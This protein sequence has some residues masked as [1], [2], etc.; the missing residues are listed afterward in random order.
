MD[1]SRTFAVAVIAALACAC[2][3]V[4]GPGDFVPSVDDKVG[5]GSTYDSTDEVIPGDPCQ[6]DNPWSCD[7]ITNEGCDGEEIACGFWSGEDPGFFCMTAATEPEGSPCDTAAG[8]WCAEGTHCMVSGDGTFGNCASFC[9]SS[10]DCVDGEDCVQLDWS[11]V[12]ATLGVCSGPL[13]PP[14]GG[15]DA[16]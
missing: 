8:P 16:G 5:E 13:D 6:E 4:K 14:D 15:S 7:P 11:P 2:G 12:E 9:C 3:D 10:D 1:V